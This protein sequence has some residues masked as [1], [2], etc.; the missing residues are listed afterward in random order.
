MLQWRAPGPFVQEERGHWSWGNFS[1]ESPEPVLSAFSFW[2]MR[3]VFE[4]VLIYQ[5]RIRLYNV[6]TTFTASWVS[7]RNNYKQPGILTTRIAFSLKK[8]DYICSL[9]IISLLSVIWSSYL[10]LFN[11]TLSPCNCIL[12]TPFLSLKEKLKLWFLRDVFC[13]LGAKSSKCFTSPT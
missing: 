1:F 6:L 8:R 5:S 12:S 13:I 9:A 2:N 3:N 11:I 4:P 7:L 10:H